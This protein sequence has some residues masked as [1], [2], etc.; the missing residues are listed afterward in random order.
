M[1]PGDTGGFCLISNKNTLDHSSL[2]AVNSSGMIGLSMIVSGIIIVGRVRVAVNAVYDVFRQLL[3]R[4]SSGTE[5][6]L[7]IR[8]VMRVF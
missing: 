4:H 6:I 8:D 1:T 3:F 5:P 2:R 7:D